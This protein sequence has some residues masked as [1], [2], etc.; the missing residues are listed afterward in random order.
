MGNPNTPKVEARG[1]G[2][3]V[4]LS[5]TELQTNQRSCLKKFTYKLSVG[6]HDGIILGIPALKRLRQESDCEFRASL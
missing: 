3:Q 5:Y 6:R 2:V 4:I 1:L